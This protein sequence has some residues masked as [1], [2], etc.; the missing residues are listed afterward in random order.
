MTL[1]GV[2]VAG[3]T[4]FPS[5]DNEE[6]SNGLCLLPILVSTFEAG[7]FITVCRSSSQHAI[8][9]SSILI[10][11]FWTVEKASCFSPASSALRR[12]R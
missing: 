10:G 12:P 9:G 11:V 5:A 2:W 3:V 6:R 7:R 8:A 1:C 4:I